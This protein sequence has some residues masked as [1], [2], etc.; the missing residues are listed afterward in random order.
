MP[1]TKYQ[2]FIVVGG[3]LIALFALYFFGFFTTTQY[4]IT[5]DL[6]QFELVGERVQEDFTAYPLVALNEDYQL[7]DTYQD[8]IAITYGGGGDTTLVSPDMSESLSL[9]FPQSLSQPL[10]ITLPGNKLITVTHQT[11]QDT[12]SELLT[13]TPSDLPL[14]ESDVTTL[15]NE[16][17]GGS[18]AATPQPQY[19]KY[20]TLD[21]RQHTYYAYQKDQAAG[22]RNLKHWTI[23]TDGDGTES[24]SYTFSNAHLRT[25]DR[26]EVEVRYVPPPDTSIQDQ[27]DDNLWARAQAVLAK[28]REANI[29]NTEPDLIIPAPYTIDANNNHV[30]HE[31]V[32]TPQSA[33]NPNDTSG[34]YVLSVNFEVPLLGYPIALDPTLQF[35]IGRAHV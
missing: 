8:G 13:N 5:T 23:F 15:R 30:T 14:E 20:T 27:V 3:I 11:D 12:T 24:Q 35:K 29:T 25:N 17:T 22:Y 9:D 16:T 4:T 28:D 10:T 6:A 19:L 21:S 7:T 2:L 1:G 31:W 34:D 33:I 26:G 32:V 18:F